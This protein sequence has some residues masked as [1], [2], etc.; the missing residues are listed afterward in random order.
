MSEREREVLRAYAGKRARV[1]CV[2]LCVE[3]WLYRLPLSVER[4]REREVF[5]SIRREE[6]VLIVCGVVAVQGAEAL[7]ERES[8]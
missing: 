8:G 4:E 1:L 2:R 6:R 3:W 5:E 7:S